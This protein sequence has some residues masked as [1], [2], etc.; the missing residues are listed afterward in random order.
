M[1]NVE[2][3]CLCRLHQLRSDLDLCSS[4]RMQVGLESSISSIRL[5]L[6]VAANKRDSIRDILELDTHSEQLEKLRGQLV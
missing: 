2:N 4:V 5:L 6:Y 3:L 1:F